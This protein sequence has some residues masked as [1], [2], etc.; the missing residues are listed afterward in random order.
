MKTWSTDLRSKVIEAY[1][2]GLSGSY[3]QTAKLFG[4]GEASVSRWLRRK[5]ETG[6]VKPKPKKG[7]NPRKLDLDWLREHATMHPD[8]RLIDRVEAWEAQSGIRVHIDTISS[9]LQAIGWTYKKN[10]NGKRAR[11]ARRAAETKKV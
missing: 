6:D 3:K 11:A 8:A 7:N 4:I 10:A 1:N 2:S 9:S 5:R